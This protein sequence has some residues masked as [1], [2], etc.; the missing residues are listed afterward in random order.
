[1]PAG[2]GN[3]ACA[4]CGIIDGTMASQPAPAAG[5]EQTRLRKQLG[6]GDLILAQILCVVGSLSLIHI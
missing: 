4:T 3:G 5:T 6:L 1:V 2:A